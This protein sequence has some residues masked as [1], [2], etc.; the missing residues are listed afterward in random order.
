MFLS[1]LTAVAGLALICLAIGCV[2][3]GIGL[4][5]APFEVS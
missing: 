5:A 1:A 2:F 3:G 4:A